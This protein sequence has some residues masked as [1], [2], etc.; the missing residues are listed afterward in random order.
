MTRTKSVGIAV[1]A[2]V[3]LLMGG[4]VSPAVA[5]HEGHSAPTASQPQQDAA[6][7]APA[8]APVVEIPL[9]KQQMLG[10]KTAAVSFRRIGKVIRTVGRVE[11]DERKLAT[12][13]MKYE[14]WIEKLYADYTGMQVK[15]G[16]PLAEVYSP[17]LLA[18]QQE[19]LNTLRWAKSSGEAKEGA[20]SGMLNK[21]AGA[22]IDA[23]RQR[24]RLWD[25]TDEQIRIIEETGRTVRTV[26]LVSPADGTVVQK[27]AV[28]GMRVM[29]GEKLFDIAD[30]SSVW[31]I[32]D[33][34]ENELPLINPG[35]TARITLSS[36]P[37][38]EFS[39]KIEFVY[40]TLT[41]QARTVKVRLTVA[42]PG[43]R[44]KPQMFTNV[45]IKAGIGRRLAVPDDAVLETG[46]RSIVYVDKGEGYFEPREVKLGLRADGYREVLSGL[47]AGEKV[48]RTATFLIDSEAQLKGVR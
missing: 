47:K 10:I 27:N 32:S 33:I 22:I 18:T 12:V 11:Y 36:L 8:E 39:A 28:Q 37:G 38:R 13:N 24:L 25:I 44:L 41:D 14:G 19:F 17:E 45:E 4:I 29:P 16:Q 20:V 42:N 46:T 15:K 3:A 40:P 5:Q 35:E 1:T 43:G 34:Y 21:D 26:T 9:D 48:A 2:A 30:L 23:A 31:I 6:P 7:A